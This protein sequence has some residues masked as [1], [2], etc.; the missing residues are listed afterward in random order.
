MFVEYNGVSMIGGNCK[1]SAMNIMFLFPNCKRLDL[2]LCNL[3]CIVASRVQPTIDISS[4]MMN[5]ILGHMS[6]IVLGLVIVVCLSI[7]SPNEEC[8]VVPFINNV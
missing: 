4:I 8:I 6:M 5:W 2:N 7:D 1:K 3:K